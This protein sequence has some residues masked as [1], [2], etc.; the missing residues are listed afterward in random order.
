MSSFVP[1]AFMVI[2]MIILG[3]YPITAKLHKQIVEELSRKTVS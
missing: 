1:A 3:F 2:A